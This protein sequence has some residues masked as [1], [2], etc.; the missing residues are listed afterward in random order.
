MPPAVY[1]KVGAS[2]G[3]EWHN[4]GGSAN[5]K[6]GLGD[7]PIFDSM[8]NGRSGGASSG[9]IHYVKINTNGQ[10][11][12][13]LEYHLSAYAKVVKPSDL[14]ANEMAYV[15]SGVSLSVEIT[16]HALE[17]IF[18]DGVTYRRDLATATPLANKQDSA[19]NT[20]G[21]SAVL[22][23]LRPFV[24][25]PKHIDDLEIFLDYVFDRI[26]LGWWSG[27]FFGPTRSWTD[28]RV[29]F[30][31]ITAAAS[32]YGSP[33]EFPDFMFYGFYSTNIGSV[34]RLGAPSEFLSG[35]RNLKVSVTG[36]DTAFTPAA[37]TANYTMRLHWPE[38]AKEVVSSW[39][40]VLSDPPS[41]VMDR[42]QAVELGSVWNNTDVTQ[43]IEL[44]INTSVKYTFGVTLSGGV[45]AGSDLYGIMAQLGFDVEKSTSVDYAVG[46]RVPVV[47][48]KRTTV[49]CIVKPT[50]TVRTFRTE[51]YN[52]FG[53]VSD[54]SVQHTSPSAFRYDFVQRPIL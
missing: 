39:S 9:G 43:M 37:T 5:A 6:N 31:G 25:T 10:P 46:R 15:G 44:T 20:V 26:K 18:R 22:V 41:P 34:W 35:D 14:A 13:R 53:Y 11:T 16:N 28:W 7:P 50:G 21:D 42:Y 33:I 38:E 24:T 29:E 51:K 40:G 19:G 36:V 4:G 54:S 48:P 1:I 45:S 27:H 2:A 30:N 17:L 47:A 32:D 49:T 3:A 23:R 12:V 52:R 8:Q